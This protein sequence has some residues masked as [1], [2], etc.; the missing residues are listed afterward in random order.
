MATPGATSGELKTPNPRQSSTPG[1]SG[2]A[3]SDP[4]VPDTGRTRSVQGTHESGVPDMGTAK[5]R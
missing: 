5:V 3:A 1:V 2:A 4:G